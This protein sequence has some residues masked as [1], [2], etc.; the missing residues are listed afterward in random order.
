MEDCGDYST[1]E[2]GETGLLGPWSIPPDLTPQHTGKE[3]YNL[4]PNAQIGARP[5]RTTEQALLVLASAID[6]ARKRGRVLTL[7]SFDIKGAFN[8]VNKDTLEARLRE[9]GIPQIARR[10]VQSFMENRSA[11][12]KFDDFSTE[13]ASLPNAGLAQGSPLSPILFTIFNSDLVDQPV[14][15]NGGASA[16][17]DDYFRWRTGPNA[18]SNLQKIQ[19]IDVPRIEEWARRTGSRFSAEKM[20]LIHFTGRKRDQT[21]GSI[22]MNGHTISPSPEVKLLGVYFDQEPNWKTHTQYMVKRATNTCVAIGRLSHLRP[23]QMRQLYTACVVPKLTYASTVWYNPLKGAT[24]VKALTKVQ[25]TALIRILSTFRTVATQTL[26]MEAHIPPIRARLRQRARDVVISL[27][28]LPQSHPIHGPL[29]RAMAGATCNGNRCYY[30]LEDTMRMF[31][32]EELEPIEIIDPCPPEPWQKPVFKGIYLDSDRARAIERA[33][34]IME[35]PTKAVFTDAAKENSAL[36]AAALIMDESYHIQ[37]GI[38]VGVG[39]EKHWTVTTAELLAIYHGLYLVWRSHS[40]EGTPTPHQRH[41][42]T[43]LSDSRTALRAIANSS[44]QVG[45]QI[46][47]NILHTTK[48]LRSIG[49]DLCLQ[50]VPG[51]SGIKGNEMADQ[52]AKQ[53]INPN[54]TRGFPKPASHLREASRNSTTQEWRDEWSSTAKGTHLRKI[55]AALPGQ[56]TRRLYATLPRPRARLLAQLRTGHSWLNEFRNRI[57]YA[58]DNK[59]EC[60]AKESVHHVLVDCPRLQ[61]QRRVLRQK[62]GDRFNNISLMLGGKPP[63]WTI[64]GTEWKISRGDLDAILDFAESSERFQGRDN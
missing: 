24:Q 30:P 5:G 9:M 64:N 16:F 2:T 51:H 31:H 27:R 7:V 62:I 54:P 4:L 6:Q 8:G 38:Q 10:W 58:D 17:I 15:H 21:T 26:E 28:T 35:N 55:D 29:R 50:W 22:M 57:K 48:E 49:V 37:Y 59:C 56:H 46:V 13:V 1:A 53:S 45:G 39:R 47:Q 36:G 44:K 42:Y 32:R 40:S 19:Q 34:K 23:E 12:I 20:E 18:E 41:T 11:N 3:K 33:T 52:L 25:R 61:Q 63:N 14:D 43:I 60:G